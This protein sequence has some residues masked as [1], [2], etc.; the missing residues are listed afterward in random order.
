LEPVL[1]KEGKIAMKALRKTVRA[2]ASLRDADVQ[3]HAVAERMRRAEDKGRR[4][5]LEH[6][7]CGLEASRADRRAKALE[8]L[9]RTGGQAL[10]A[11][12]PR[13]IERGALRLEQSDRGELKELVHRAVAR[14]IERALLASPPSDDEPGREQMHR[15]RL[16]LKRLRYTLELVEALAGPRAKDLLDRLKKLQ[17]LLGDH[18]D[19]VALESLFQGQLR[20][21]EAQGF[22]AL[23]AGLRSELVDLTAE[24]EQLF[25]AIRASFDSSEL[26]R[27]WNELEQSLAADASRSED[28]PGLVSVRDAAPGKLSAQSA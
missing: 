8:K 3:V 14:D 16:S 15:A 21:L 17:Q 9:N 1:P 2:T 5:A 11:S 10:P 4:A 20:Q 22:E 28:R 18:R 23:A 7:L 12:A 26:G 19:R 13:A 6:V 24:R 25:Y 27:L